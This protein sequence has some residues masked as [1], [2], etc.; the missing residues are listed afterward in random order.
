MYGLPA[1]FDATVFV[2][3]ELAQVSFTI[4]TVHLVFDDGKMAITLEGAYVTKLDAGAEA[5]R[6]SP[7]IRSSDLM[8]FIGRRVSSAEAAETGVLT[9]QF[10][11]G[12]SLACLDEMKEYEA[13]HIY[14]NGREIVV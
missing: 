2:N 7:P 11:G 12:G 4:N 6:Q 5:K 8:S 13:Y 10:E 9:L 3:Q 1:D 14:V